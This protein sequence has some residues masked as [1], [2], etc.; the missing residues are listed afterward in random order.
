MKDSPFLI[1]TIGLVIGG[2]V[3]M[4]FEHQRF[5]KEI[6]GLSKK[7]SDTPAAASAPG[8]VDTATAGAQEVQSS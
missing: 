4:L 2:V 7:H 8:V 3:G 1:L 5:L 6:Q